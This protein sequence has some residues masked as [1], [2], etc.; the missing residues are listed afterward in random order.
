VVSLFGSASAAVPAIA[1]V[2]TAATNFFILHL[3]VEFI[4][5]VILFL[6]LSRINYKTIK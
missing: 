4:C 5:Y 6:L 2:A 1:S 3:L